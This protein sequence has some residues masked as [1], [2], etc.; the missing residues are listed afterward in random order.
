[1]LIVQ[2]LY[3][4]ILS[5]SKYDKQVNERLHSGAFHFLTP[6]NV[7]VHIMLY[8]MFSQS[9]THLAKLMQTEKTEDARRTT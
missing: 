7:S 6:E 8:L 9:C 2:A 4:S 5:N 3:D 1:M